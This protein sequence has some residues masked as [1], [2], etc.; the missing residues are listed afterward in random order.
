MNR[1]LGKKQLE[2]LIA[3]KKDRRVRFRPTRTGR[4]WPVMLSLAKRGMIWMAREQASFW[5]GGDFSKRYETIHLFGLTT[6]GLMAAN[7]ELDRRA[8]ATAPE[9]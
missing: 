1:P 7:Q 9:G 8:D 2:F 6:D 4:P 5:E 3:Y